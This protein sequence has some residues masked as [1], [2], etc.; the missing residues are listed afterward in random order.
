MKKT[1]SVINGGRAEEKRRGKEALEKLGQ[2]GPAGH[3]VISGRVE[4]KKR[5]QKA[6]DRTAALEQALARSA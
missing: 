2:A 5:A 6:R 4:K 3:E 1:N